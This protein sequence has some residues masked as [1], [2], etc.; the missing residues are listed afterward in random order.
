[1]KLGPSKVFRLLSIA[2]ARAAGVP[3]PKCDPDNEDQ[4]DKACHAVAESTD[5]LAARIP[6]WAE[7]ESRL[8][9]HKTYS[10]KD[11]LEWLKNT[12]GITVGQ[13]SVDRDRKRILNAERVNLLA[14]QRLKQSLDLLSDLPDTDLFSGGMRM[15]GQMI[16]TNLL[17]YS[18]DTLQNLRPA[19]I[20]SMM[21]VFA[22]TSKNYAEGLLIAERQKLA[23]QQRER[24]DAET[25]RAQTGSR[26]GKISPGQLEQIRAAVF[27]EAAA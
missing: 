25:K 16:L 21:D 13:S 5:G 15:I 18:A 17:N 26:D 20:I 24:F 27:G 12:W 6:A 2:A 8:R 9:D 1:M 4:V 3:L 7:Y 23:K 14:N 22:R 19:Q 11:S 10:L